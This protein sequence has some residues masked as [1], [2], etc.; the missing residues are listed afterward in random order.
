MTSEGLSVQ[1]VIPPS[2]HPDTGKAYEW[3][4]DYNNLVELP[5]SI[6]NWWLELIGADLL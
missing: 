5:E 1:D 3:R 2:I 6:K 4:G